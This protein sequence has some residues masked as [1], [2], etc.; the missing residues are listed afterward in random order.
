VKGRGV[1][2]ATREGEGRGVYLATR[3]GEGEGCLP[4]YRGLRE[5]GYAWSPRIVLGVFRM[6]DI[7]Y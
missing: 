7:Y 3:E 1:Y 6:V 4:G 5:G 2:L